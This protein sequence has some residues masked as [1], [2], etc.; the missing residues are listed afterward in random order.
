MALSKDEGRKV[1]ECT[2][3]ATTGALAPFYMVGAAGR[4]L[5]REEKRQRPVDF[6]RVGFTQVRSG[7]WSVGYWKRS[8]GGD[9]NAWPARGG[10]TVCCYGLVTGGRGRPRVGQS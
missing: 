7:E 2:L 8:I 5:I 4:W 3:K 1:G 10:G 6:E 9:G